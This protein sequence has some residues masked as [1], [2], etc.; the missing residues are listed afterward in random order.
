[1]Y[2][3]NDEFQETQ[4]RIELG[5]RRRIAIAAHYEVR[6]VLQANSALVEHGLA[7]ILIGSYARSVSIWPGKDVDILGRLEAFTINSLDPDAAYQLFLDALRVFDR[8]GRLTEQPRSL[9]VDFGADKAPSEASIRSTGLEFGW[10]RSDVDRL[11]RDASDLMF[12][13]SVDVVPAVRWDDHYGIPELAI[14]ALGVRSRRGTWQKT[15]PVKLNELT[16]LR[17]NKP[18]I[19]GTG[20]FVRTVKAIKQVKT[21]HLPDTKPSSLFYEFILHEGF[22]DGSITGDTWAEITAS[23]L[24]FIARRM[25]TVSTDPICDPVLGQAYEPVPS[26]AS[27]E[28]CREVFADLAAKATFAVSSSDRC[29]AA[30]NWRTVFGGNPRHAKVFPLPPGCRGTGAEQGA[31]AMNMS[32]GGT[33]ER[34]FGRR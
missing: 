1:M 2:P 10:S 19:A 29:Q 22:A 18:K 21:H 24:D 5:D 26:D 6:E 17:N 31:A 11:V 14:S 13:F 3:F 12:E 8:V 20:A 28:T 4:K 23:A 30:I 7:D 27:L 9:K 16:S 25:G 15:N 32:S 34:S 33:E